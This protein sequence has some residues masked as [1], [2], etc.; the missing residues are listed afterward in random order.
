MVST[1]EKLPLSIGGVRPR[2]GVTAKLS[3][4][5]ATPLVLRE[6]IMMPPET[7]EETVKGDHPLSVFTT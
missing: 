7:S 2:A 4:V 3:T 5:V 6:A 1:S